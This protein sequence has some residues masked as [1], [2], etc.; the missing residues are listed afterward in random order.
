[1]TSV[2]SKLYVTIVKRA[3]KRSSKLLWAH[4]EVSRLQIVVHNFQVLLVNEFGKYQPSGF[5][6]EKCHATCHVRGNIKRYG[7]MKKID[8]VLYES[9]YVMFKEKY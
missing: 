7:N 3:L 8:T 1:M 5:C 9:Q 6:T 2:I 4:E